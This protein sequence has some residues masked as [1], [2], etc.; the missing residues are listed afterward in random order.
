MSIQ[1]AINSVETLTAL[2]KR[3]GVSYQAVQKWVANGVPADRCAAVE[4][5]TG[6]RCEEL[7]PDLQWLRNEAGEVTGYTVPVRA[8]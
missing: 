5:A 1:A 4:S 6:V 2:A 7:R 3:L 8:A